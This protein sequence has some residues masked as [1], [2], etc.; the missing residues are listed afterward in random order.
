MEIISE[1]TD[2]K[3][4]VVLALN[5]LPDHCAVDVGELAKRISVDKLELVFWAR[6]DIEFARLLASKVV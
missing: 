2:G 5:D 1:V 6:A 4:L 3:R